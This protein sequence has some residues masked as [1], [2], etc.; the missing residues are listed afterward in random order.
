M[1]SRKTKAELED[2][3]A[4]LEAQLARNEPKEGEPFDVSPSQTLQ[5]HVYAAVEISEN[6]ASSNTVLQVIKKG[7]NTEFF[8]SEFSKGQM[9]KTTKMTFK[10]D[11][12]I[13]GIKL[14]HNQHYTSR[15]IPTKSQT[16]K[17]KTGGPEVHIKGSHDWELKPHKDDEES[18][19]CK[20]AGYTLKF[21]EPD[22]IGLAELLE[23]RLAVMQVKD[24]NG[25]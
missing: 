22:L 5:V 19:E 8:P 2:E 7:Q 10:T 18:A 25:N 21:H 4:K 17:A 6:K 11:D 16:V 24:D 15:P 13:E 14:F 20:V 1:G 23:K 3:I 12:L 9:P